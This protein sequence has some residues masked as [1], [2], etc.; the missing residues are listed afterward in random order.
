LV[1]GVANRLEKSEKAVVKAALSS[2]GA[3]EDSEQH[4][5]SL[6]D[7]I[8]LLCRVFKFGEGEWDV[9]LVNELDQIKLRN[10]PSAEA[11]EDAQGPSRRRRSQNEVSLKWRQLK[12]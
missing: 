4:P 6:K 5:W 11:G 9:D 3:G 7:L 1:T 10:T 2:L 12:L 8:A